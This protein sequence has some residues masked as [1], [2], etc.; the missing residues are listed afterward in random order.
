ME[1]DGIH[2]RWRDNSDREE[3]TIV[4]RCHGVACTTFENRAGIAPDQPP[5]FVD[6]AIQPGVTY[7]YRVYAAWG[8]PEGPMG[9]G[10]SNIVEATP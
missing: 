5:E 7:R 10:P 1:E 3:L 4:Q 8:T 6:D 9:T 2:L